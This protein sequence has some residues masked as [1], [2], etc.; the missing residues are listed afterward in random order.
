MFVISLQS[1]KSSEMNL[2]L[3]MMYSSPD[4]YP[5]LLTFLVD[6]LMQKKKQ[7]LLLGMQSVVYNV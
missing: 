4:N 7:K 6:C 3:T 5:M 1:G 2:T